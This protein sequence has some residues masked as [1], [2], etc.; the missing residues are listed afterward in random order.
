M[1]IEMRFVEE[2]LD[3][4]KRTFRRLKRAFGSQVVATFRF[5]MR[6]GGDLYSRQ[7]I[8]ALEPEEGA[9]VERWL[10]S[11]YGRCVAE[12]LKVR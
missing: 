4:E 10:T 11:H 1:D 6:K 8:A 12:A 5:R 3:T 7:S 9:Y 2:N